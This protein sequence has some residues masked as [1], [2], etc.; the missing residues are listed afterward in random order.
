MIQVRRIGH[1]TFETPDLDKAVDYYAAVNG[2][3][4]IG[5]GD[6]TAYLASR[7]GLLTIALQCADAARC[8][9]LTFE[10][11]PD[12]DLAAVQKDLAAEGVPSERRSDPAPGIAASLLLTDPNGTGVELY[13]TRGDLAVKPVTAGVAPLKLGHVAFFTPDPDK[14]GKFYQRFLGFRVSDWIEDFFLF[15]RCNADHHAVNFLRGDKPR[16]H[17]IAFELKDVA[18][19]AN[20]CD[21]LAKNKIPIVWGP[22]RLGPGH[23]IATFHREHDGQMVEFYTELDQMKDE[24]LGYF[25]PRPWHRD[26][27]QRP[28]VWKLVDDPIWGPPPPPNFL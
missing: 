9:R 4:L 13:A 3:T 10:V 25:D 22:I 12:S 27:V 14:V 8:A 5:R 1:A 21:V 19:I 23:N 28:K 7:T 17:H 2:L 26:A 18:H 15:M 24:A 16:M 6:Q 11:A 20:S